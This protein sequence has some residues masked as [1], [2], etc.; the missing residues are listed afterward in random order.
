MLEVEEFL[1]LLAHVP[2]AVVHLGAVPSRG[3]HE[4]GEDLRNV[5]GRGPLLWRLVTGPLLL[6]LSG[7][8]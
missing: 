3:Q 5:E 4:I 7:G 8:R 1:V 2:E 6:L